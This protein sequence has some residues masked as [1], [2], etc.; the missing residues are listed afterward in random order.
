MRCVFLYFRF[1]KAQHKHFV[2]MQLGDTISSICDIGLAVLFLD[3][4]VTKIR[5]IEDNKNMETPSHSHNHD[6][7]SSFQDA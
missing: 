6:K 7:P 4:C 3:D 5:N 2:W 1:R